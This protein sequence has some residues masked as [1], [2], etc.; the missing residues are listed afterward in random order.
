MKNTNSDKL[1]V[2][3]LLILCL[4][5]LFLICINLYDIKIRKTKH[6]PVSEGLSF[7]TLNLPTDYG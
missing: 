1:Y 6:L 3:I 4:I 5:S 2:K 7:N